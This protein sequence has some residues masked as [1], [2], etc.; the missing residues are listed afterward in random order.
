MDRG[1]G[2]SSIIWVGFGLLSYYRYT[3]CLET[4]SSII[5]WALGLVI[6]LVY[7][8]FRKKRGVVRVQIGVLN[9][10]QFPLLYYRHCIWQEGLWDHIHSTG[11][12]FCANWCPAEEHKNNDEFGNGILKMSK[13]RAI[14]KSIT[15]QWVQRT[16]PTPFP[17]GLDVMKFLQD[18][19]LLYRLTTASA[20]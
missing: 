7:Y 15:I 3:I 20:E 11:W 4:L 9:R 19:K 16:G 14:A 12:R 18:R 2:N 10:D 8:T 17:K 13:G 6:G 1:R 5:F